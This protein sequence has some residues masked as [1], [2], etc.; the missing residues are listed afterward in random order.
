MPRRLM[1]NLEGE[2]IDEEVHEC[3]LGDDILTAD[4]NGEDSLLLNIC[5]YCAFSVPHNVSRLVCCER[6]GKVPEPLLHVV[7]ECVSAF[8]SHL[9]KRIS[10]IMA[11]AAV[12]NPTLKRHTVPLVLFLRILRCCTLP[13]P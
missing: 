11:H 13:P 1:D 6:V 2:V 7:S 3:A 4:L 10:R 8:V 9:D 12:Q 5:E